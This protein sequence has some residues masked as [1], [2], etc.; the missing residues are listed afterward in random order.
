MPST[1]PI[2]E[3]AARKVAEQLQA[4]Q[5]AAGAIRAA[6]PE[7]GA[8]AWRRTRARWTRSVSR[9]W[10]VSTSRSSSRAWRPRAGEPLDI[11]TLDLDMRRIYGRGDFEHVGYRLIDEPDHRILAVQAVEKAWGPDLRALRPVAVQRLPRRQRLQPAGQLPPHLAQPP[12]RRMAHRPAAGQRRLAVHRVLPAAGAEPVLLHRA[13][14][15]GWRAGRP[16]STAAPT[17]TTWRR[18]TTSASAPSG[19]DLGSQ[20]TKYG[21]LRVGV[22]GRAGRRRPADRRPG[23]GAVHI[24]R[25]IG[26]VRTRLYLDQ[27]DSTSFPRTGYSLDAQVLA[28]TTQLGA[29]DTY[30]RWTANFVGARSFG[31]HTFQ[32][33]AGRRRHARRRP[34][35][36]CTTT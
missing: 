14:R 4:L 31:P 13:A 11:A 24:K 23:A 28:S 1:I 34:A 36:R 25:D 26:A 35:C 29:S 2:G 19:L 16:T 15:A 18:A 20:F 12:G 17:A 3:A 5:P 30:N 8:R 6:P 32:V 27:L 33:A 22:L 21:E 10:S 9:A 7:P